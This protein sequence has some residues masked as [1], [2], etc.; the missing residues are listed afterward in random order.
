MANARVRAD[1][2]ATQAKEVEA[3]LRRGYALHRQQVSETGLT[4]CYR[5]G[6][7]QYPCNRVGRKVI[8]SPVSVDLKAEHDK[9]I[10]LKQQQIA[11]LEYALSQRDICARL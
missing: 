8:E 2:L 1:A 6:K 9:L 11:A 7:G 3:T 5:R 4:M 10:R